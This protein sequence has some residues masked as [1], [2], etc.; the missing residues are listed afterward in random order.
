MNQID[1]LK[2]LFR[3]EKIGDVGNPGTIFWSYGAGFVNI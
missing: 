3:K 1:G 2:D